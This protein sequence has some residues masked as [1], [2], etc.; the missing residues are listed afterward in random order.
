M[1]S[2]LILS[3][4]IVAQLQHK[5]LFQRYMDVMNVRWTLKYRYVPAERLL[6]MSQSNPCAEEFFVYNR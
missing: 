6:F 4:K 5:T 2:V 1:P 3:L